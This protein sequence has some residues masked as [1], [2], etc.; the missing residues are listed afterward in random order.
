KV[1]KLKQTEAP[2]FKKST[3]KST[4]AKKEQTEIS[5]SY[6]IIEPSI[7]AVT[8]PPCPRCETGHLIPFS[9]VVNVTSRKKEVLP[10]AK[11]ICSNCGFSPKGF[12]SNKRK[13]L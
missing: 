10:F 2:P 4:E 5:T 11:W 1:K 6:S 7:E 13:R 9:D 12:D 8:T 3:K